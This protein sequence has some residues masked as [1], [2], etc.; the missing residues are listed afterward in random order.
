MKRPITRLTLFA[1]INQHLA[2]H[3]QRLLKTLP[4]DSKRLGTYHT[5]S[6]FNGRVRVMEH[7]TVSL[8]EIGIE[9]GVLSDNEEV[10]DD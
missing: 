7:W 4:K 2:R 1:R 10:V 5:V 9:L 8:E 3:G 6:V